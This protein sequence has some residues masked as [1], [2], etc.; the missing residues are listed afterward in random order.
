MKKRL[1][2]ISFFVIIFIAFIVVW[3]YSYQQGL[4]EAYTPIIE[5]PTGNFIPSEGGVFKRFNTENIDYLNMPLDENHQRTLKEYYKNRAY[6]GAPPSIPHTVTKERSLGGDTCL[7]CHQNGGFVDKFNAYAPVTPHPEMINCRQCHVTKNTNTTFKEFVTSNSN[8][9]FKKVA[10]PKVGKG[11]NNAM[12]GSPPMIPHQ[13]QMR[14]NC[15]SCHAGPSAPKEI[16]VSHPERIN[17][18]QCHVPKNNTALPLDTSS[19]I[20]QF[21]TIDNE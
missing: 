10:P 21:N 11:E 2:I 15:I 12:P 16:R 9:G 13:L 19:F 14:E 1:G 5:T 6:P 20:R 18:R 7:Q 8:T 3:N 17:C 4:E